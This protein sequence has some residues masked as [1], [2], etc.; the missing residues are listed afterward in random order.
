MII[1]YGH[2]TYG[3]VDEQ[4]GQHAV[5]RFAH[6]YY[7]P[8]FPTS[9][10]WMTSADRGI[11][12]KMSGKSVLA[13]YARTWGMVGA[14]GC[15]FAALGGGGIL[16]GLAAVALGTASISSWSWSKRRTE[17]ALLRGNLNALA[18]G[19]YCAPELFDSSVA[20]A[21]RERLAT[22]RLKGGMNRPPEDVARFGSRNIDEL[23]SAYGLLCLHG[24]STS[25]D[26]EALLELKAPTT[27][28]REGIY[29]DGHEGS[30]A[31]DVPMAVAI[32]QAA[33]EL[34][35]G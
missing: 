27:D 26:V 9:S 33:R 22:R 19:T 24:S 25:A 7:M 14:I 4:G 5:T 32:D 18:F 3:A 23:A 20:T 8:L 10:M 29:R 12:I 13:A 15:V 2:R 30:V 16:T 1:I 21:M 11:P 31:L 17:Q 28:G 35:A 34:M 6:V